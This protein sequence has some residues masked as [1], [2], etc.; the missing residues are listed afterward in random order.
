MGGGGQSNHSSPYKAISL[1]EGRRDVAKEEVSEIGST[2]MT[3]PIVAV[4][5]DGRV[6]E[7]RNASRH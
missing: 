7:P 1:A 2:R 5:E 4:F 3:E 6:H